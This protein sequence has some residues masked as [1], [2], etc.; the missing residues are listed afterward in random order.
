MARVLAVD[1]DLTVLTLI[2]RYLRTAGHEVLM[3]R[4]GDDALVQ[5]RASRFD[6]VVCDVNMPGKTGF[7]VLEAIRADAGLAAQPFV[8]LTSEDDRDSIRRGMRLG[9][10]DFLSK[11]ADSAELVESIARVLDKKRRLSSL[12]AATALSSSGEMRAHYTSALTQTE[13]SAPPLSDSIS[14]PD[15]ITQPD[16]G[17]FVQ[18]TSEFRTIT[19]CAIDDFGALS[20]RMKSEELSALLD[21]YLQATIQTILAHGGQVL[22]LTGDGVVAVFGHRPDDAPSAAARA[23]LRAAVEIVRHASADQL[24]NTLPPSRIVP[25]FKVVAGVHSGVVLA[26]DSGD[27]LSISGEG[28]DLA[29]ALRDR[30]AS[31]GWRVIA[32][33]AA[34]EVAGPECE[35]EANPAQLLDAGGRKTL[36]VQQLVSPAQTAKVAPGEALN[37]ALAA[38][39]RETARS[40]A[41]AS[42][43]ALDGALAAINDAQSAEFELTPSASGGR[44][45]NRLPPI[46]GYR[47]ERKIGEGGMSTV[48]LADSDAREGKVVLK[49]LKGRRD[50]DEALWAR[51][52]QECAILS[53]IKHE[54]VVRIYDQGFGDE[55][56]YIAMEH[57]AGGGLAELIRSGVTPRQA[58]SL[59]S[60]AASALAEIH[61]R[62]ILHR[63]IK[64]ANFLLRA[65]SVLVLTDFGVAKRVGQKL[66]HTLQGEVLGTPHYVSPEQAQGELVTPASDVYG[67]GV[68]FHELLCGRRPFEG[69]TLMEILS[70]HLTAPIPRLP[71]ELAEYQP[72]INGML[73]KQVENRFP[74]AHAVLDE[75]DR[76]WTVQAVRKMKM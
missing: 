45:Q 23:A 48:Y 56:A 43:E 50:D 6:V 53:S 14:V 65:Q 3:A 72:L 58:M 27:S 5:L 12:V 4:D 21:T 51:F 7:E 11:P 25:P 29:C 64:P 52:F 16:V 49:V 57:L 9:A 75:I 32:S 40:G 67:L 69:E 74:S 31:L 26:D 44:P 54:H 62:G 38:V 34:I 60:Q 22:K 19:A 59:L 71:E 66:S 1:D 30:A 63:D 46:R 17:A 73:A 10:D 13:G 47:I 33:T 41:Q 70:Q 15:K 20:G 37:A 76:V 28:V 61:R 68:I 36:S 42:K 55:F 24:Q 18:R 2:R 8:L 39:L 35:I